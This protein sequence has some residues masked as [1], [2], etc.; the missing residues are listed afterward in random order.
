MIHFD[1]K[2]PSILE[3]EFLL[4]LGYLG[5]SDVDKKQLLTDII[6]FLKPF[7]LD[8]TK[9]MYKEDTEVLAAYLN[10]YFGNDGKR[11]EFIKCF[12]RANSTSNLVT[13]GAILLVDKIQ[14]HLEEDGFL[15][16]NEIDEIYAMLLIHANLKHIPYFPTLIGMQINDSLTHFFTE[17]IPLEFKDL[18]SRKLPATFIKQRILELLTAIYFLHIDLKLA[19]R[20]IKPENIRFRSNGTLVLLD[21]DTACVREESTW[22]T[23]PVTSQHTRAP[24]LDHTENK[25]RYNGYAVDIFSAGCVMLIMCLECKLPFHNPPPKTPFHQRHMDILTLFT[26]HVIQNKIKNC[27]GDLAWDLMLKMLAFNPVDRPDIR[28]C[29]EHPFFK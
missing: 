8:E 5:L 29:L 1:N 25:E 26:K 12:Q 16:F 10:D 22:S 17:F 15:K 18:F 14:E 21:Y 27:I 24:E 13:D 19:H 4:D 3:D 6:T 9:C 11:Y 7:A 23:R 2:D 28:T 20:D